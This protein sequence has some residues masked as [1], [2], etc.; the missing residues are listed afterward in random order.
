[1][2]LRPNVAEVTT[3]LAREA[4]DWDGLMP[5][6]ALAE[7]VASGSEDPISD[8]MEHCEFRILILPHHRSHSNCAGGIFPSYPS[9]VPQSP[10][11]SQ[12]TSGPFSRPSTP[13]T[14][15]SELSQE[16]HLAVLTEYL[17]KPQPESQV[18]MKPQSGEPGN[19]PHALGIRPRACPHV[20]EIHAHLSQGCRPPPSELPEEKRGGFKHFISKVLRSYG[21][22]H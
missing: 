12:A 11:E 17:P 13:S 16:V 21:L 19:D 9:V 10:T 6:C 1:M 8:S 3:H 7:N 15:C 18:P 22:K 14:Q 2:K 20:P 4:A 5:P